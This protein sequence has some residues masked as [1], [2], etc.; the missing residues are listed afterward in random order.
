[1]NL[2]F[3]RA[4]T[5]LVCLAVS[6]CDV[7]KSSSENPNPAAP[8]PSPSPATPAGPTLQSVTLGPTGV[9]P[10]FYATGGTNQTIATGIFS[11]G[12]RQNITSSCTD[13]QS[14]NTFVLTINNEGVITARN[15][16]SATITTTCQGVFGRGLVTLSVIPTTPWTW[17]GTGFQIVEMPLYVERLRIT[18]Q[19]N[20][21]VGHQIIVS[22]DGGSL[23][24]TV[25]GPNARYDGT[26]PVPSVPQSNPP[27]NFISVYV[28]VGMSTTWTLTE[29]R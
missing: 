7:K 28:S 9:P 19:S 12:S 3:V 6:A 14:D 18:V 22:T 17:S 16:G 5:L 1:M 15:S 23:L 11:D 26:H 8:T 4:S 29:V 24:N 20:V 2:F 21:R 13:W 25:L 27:S 10:R